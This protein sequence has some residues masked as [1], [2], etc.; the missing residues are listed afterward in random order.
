MICSVK[1]E[2]DAVRLRVNNYNCLAAV[3]ITYNDVKAC[4]IVVSIGCEA[5]AVI[6]EDAEVVSD[7][8]KSG[9]ESPAESVIL[10]CDLD[11]VY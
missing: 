1:C 9:I 5:C 6:R 7:S 8:R 11:F 3:F 4:V 10:K 2:V